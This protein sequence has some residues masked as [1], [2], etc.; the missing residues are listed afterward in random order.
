MSGDSD[1]PQLEVFVPVFGERCPNH[2]VIA[3]IGFVALG[4]G[5]AVTVLMIFFILSL[6]LGHASDIKICE[7]FFLKEGKLKLNRN[8]EVL[9]CGSRDDTQGWREVPLIQAE[10]HLKTILQNLGYFQ[11]RF[12]RV[13]RQLLIWTGAKSK[14]KDLKI[15]GA[16]EFLD[17]SKKR[18]IVGHALISA[19]IDEVQ[20]WANKGI[21]TNGYACPEIS[22][23]AHEWSNTLLVKTK[24]GGQKRIRS[25]TTENLEGLDLDILDRYR[26][27]EIRD[28]YNIQ[29][30]QIMTERLI[31]DGLFQSAFFETTCAQ[32]EAFLNLQTSIGKPKIFRF[33]VGA[34]TE[35]LPFVDFSFRNARL[36]KQASS[37]T[38]NIHVSP[39][40]QSITAESEL[41]WFQGWSKIFI[42]PRFK[43]SREVES[44]YKTDS[45]R[46]GADVGRKWD[47]WNTRFIGK[48]GSSLNFAK[49]IR[50]IGPD[51]VK[52]P[53]LDGTLFMMSHSYESSIRQQF[54]GWNGSI[55]FRGRAEGL[56]SPANVGRYEINYKYLWNMGGFAPPLFVLGTRVQAITL[57]T[58]ED[59]VSLTPVE[60]RVF[61]GGDENL[62]GFS[63]QS[64]NNHGLGYLSFL[65]L[66]FEL[67]LIDELPYRLRP[68]LLLDLAQTGNRRYTLDPPVFTSRGAGLKW[69]SPFG[70]FRGSLA[71]GKAVRQENSI[72]SYPEQWVFYLSFGKEF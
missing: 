19:N 13:N 1:F 63:R 55:F 43:L 72:V 25:L 59:Q 53:S 41:Y 29:K 10:F 21:R 11:P 66:G 45:G 17:A 70:T 51:N 40:R 20:A 44:T 31:A 3:P 9:V 48:V 16:R 50:G 39:R 46:I 7:N 64:I 14:I 68:Y 67:Q 60:D 38:A 5:R 61:V 22:V 27:F 52:Y 35:E 49:T 24:L 32:D 62:R 8:E 2:G 56:G 69:P 36:D 15:D 26:P 30:T 57:D 28:F 33:G 18:N 71:K 47:M 23:E 6:S 4:V 37:L 65:Y 58:S 54:E 34:S 12:Q 42:G